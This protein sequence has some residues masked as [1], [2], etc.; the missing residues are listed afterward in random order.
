MA[1]RSKIEERPAKL[2]NNQQKWRTTSKKKNDQKNQQKP[3][4]FM[5][6]KEKGL[7]PE[8]GG[9]KATTKIV[10]NQNGSRGGEHSETTVKTVAGNSR[11]THGAAGGKLATNQN[12]TRWRGELSFWE[13]NKNKNK[14]GRGEETKE[15][16][17]L[18]RITA[19]KTKG[20]ELKLTAQKMC[21][22]GKSF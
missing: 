11:P 7:Q 8:E 2:K 17:T 14:R 13:P 16:T 15:N 4:N 20:L 1:Q 6:T 19:M 21:A 18:T 10:D 12:N 22:L 5:R 3:N 9:L